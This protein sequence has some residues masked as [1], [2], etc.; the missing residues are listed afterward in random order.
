MNFFSWSTNEPL[1]INKYGI[2]E[3][4]SNEI[5]YPNILLI[6]LVAFDKYFNRLEI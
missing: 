3:P 4:T 5:K 1:V 2:P 6:P